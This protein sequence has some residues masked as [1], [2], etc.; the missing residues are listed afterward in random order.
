VYF[1]GDPRG[2]QPPHL[3]SR[4]STLLKSAPGI[5]EPCTRFCPAMCTK[6]RLTR[7]LELADE[8][9][10]L[11]LCI[12]NATKTCENINWVPPREEVKVQVL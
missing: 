10:L 3:K 4:I 1:Q 12:A 9:E 11:Q 5:P 7:R 2:K 6:W 8:I